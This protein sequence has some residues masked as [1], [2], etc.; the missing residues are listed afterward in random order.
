MGEVR[1]TRND[2]RERSEHEAGGQISAGKWETCGLL[3]GG[4]D[5]GILPSNTLQDEEVTVFSCVHVCVL[6]HVQPWDPVDCSPPDSF[7]PWILQ[8]RILEWVAMPS[9][10]GS[11]WPRNRNLISSPA[12][13]V[14]FL[15]TTEP[16][17]KPFSTMYLSTNNFYLPEASTTGSPGPQ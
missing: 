1:N 10:R 6:S 9:S 7:C 4:R 12:L 11:S 17:S 5:H 16:L 14:D 2:E 8:A 3:C 13:Q 15:F